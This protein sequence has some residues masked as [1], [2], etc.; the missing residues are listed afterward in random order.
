MWGSLI[1]QAASGFFIIASRAVGAGS[2]SGVG[3][4]LRFPFVLSSEAMHPGPL[5]PQAGALVAETL[6]ALNSHRF[7]MFPAP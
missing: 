2:S 7:W 4:G 1:L 3:E 5:P 6:G